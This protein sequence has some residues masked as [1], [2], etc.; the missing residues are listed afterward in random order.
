MN[1]L[2]KQI[3]DKGMTLYE[4]AKLTGISTATIY[5]YADAESLNTMPLSTAFKIAKVLGV[6]VEDLFDP[7]ITDV[8]LKE[9]WN[10]ISSSLE[11]YIEDW[12]VIKGISDGKEVYPYLPCP[13]G[14]Y[15][16]VSGISVSE[17]KKLLWF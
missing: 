4:I 12:Q 11:V 7:F 15:D 8:P 5:K 16:N 2:R 10:K 1:T 17:I 13:Y 14:G 3:E 6:A 9:G